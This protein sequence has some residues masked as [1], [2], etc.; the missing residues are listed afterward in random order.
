MLPARGRKQS[1]Q[2]SATFSRNS[3]SGLASQSRKR[4]GLTSPS[5]RMRWILPRLGASIPHSGRCS[6]NRSSVQQ[7]LTPVRQAA[8]RMRLPRSALAARHQYAEVRPNGAHPRV[9][10]ERHDRHRRRRYAPAIA[11]PCWGRLVAPARSW[12]S[13]ILGLPEVRCGLDAAQ[14][15]CNR[16]RAAA[17]RAPCARPTP[18]ERVR[19]AAWP[20]L[21]AVDS[22][23]QVLG[24]TFRMGD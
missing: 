6:F 3:G 23:G 15:R 11:T 2:I 24:A 14:P 13:T 10:S 9:R 20:R 22:S 18:D 17:P 4:C 12:S 7:P 21:P 19:P 1:A 5:V 8:G 16:E